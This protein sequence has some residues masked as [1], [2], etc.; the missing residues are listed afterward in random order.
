M[1]AAVP[2]HHDT[3]VEPKSAENAGPNAIRTPALSHRMK[4]DKS[5]LALAV[6]SRYIFAGTQGGEILVRKLDHV[7]GYEADNVQVYSLDTYERRSVIHAH[8][9]SVL[10]LCLPQDGNWLFSSAADPI[11]NVSGCQ[12]VRRAHTD[13]PGVVYVNL[14]ARL[15]PVVTL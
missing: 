3:L 6:S 1:P 8:K 14:Q 4:H 2:P 9:G 5:I 7:T 12:N 10:G 13:P 15:R 11:V